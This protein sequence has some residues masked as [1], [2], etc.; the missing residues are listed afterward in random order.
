MGGVTEHIEATT[1]AE[2]KKKTQEW[3]RRAREIGMEVHSG[4]NWKR[5]EETE[6]GYRIRVHAHMNRCAEREREHQ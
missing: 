3:S 4:W 5:V 2:L 6:T 1:F